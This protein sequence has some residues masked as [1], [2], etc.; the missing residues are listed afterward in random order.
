MGG[1]VS[2]GSG[3]RRLFLAKQT[4]PRPKADFLDQPTRK[5]F[6]INNAILAHLMQHKEGMTKMANDEVDR[7]N[8]R[9]P[10]ADTEIGDTTMRLMDGLS[11]S[12]VKRLSAQTGK[13]EEQLMVVHFPAMDR[14]FCGE[15]APFRRFALR[16]SAVTCPNCKKEK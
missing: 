2:I 11:R 9:M 3:R 16:D 15:K 6:R 14:R 4:F 5:S 12:M 8:A 13:S 10:K 1:E 7:I